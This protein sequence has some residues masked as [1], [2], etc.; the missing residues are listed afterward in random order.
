MALAHSASLEHNSFIESTNRANKNMKDQVKLSN[1]GLALCDRLMGESFIKLKLM[2]RKSPSFYNLLNS[3]SSFID[4]DQA[5]AAITF[6][7][8][9]KE[10]KELKW[11]QAN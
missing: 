5:M 7:I 9:R 10:Q 2:L 3:T 1:W 11:I 6:A 8:Y 4:E